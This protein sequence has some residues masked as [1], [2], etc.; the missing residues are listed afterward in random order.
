MSRFTRAKQRSW[1][2]FTQK[3][4][5]LVRHQHEIELFTK[6]TKQYGSL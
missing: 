3:G 5:L 6:Q 4:D 2:I 1:T